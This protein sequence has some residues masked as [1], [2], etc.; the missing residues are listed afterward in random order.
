MLESQK[1]FEFVVVLDLTP[2]YCLSCIGINASAASA[3]GRGF[4]PSLNHTSD[5]ESGTLLATL[6][7]KDTWCYV[8]IVR[9][10]WLGVS[11]LLLS[12]KA[13]LT[14]DFC[15]IVAAG[16]IVSSGSVEE[17]HAWRCDMKQSL[18]KLSARLFLSVICILP[19]DL[20]VDFFPSSCLFTFVCF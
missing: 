7:K 11:I 20:S 18:D 1:L 2:F 17:K 15:L 6:K 16:K 12:E 9:T 10:S 3:K 4:K 14:C 19:S 13:T 5:L 8:A